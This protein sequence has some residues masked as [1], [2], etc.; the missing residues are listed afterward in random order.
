MT[1]MCRVLDAC[2]R[3]YYKW[4]LNRRS[5]RQVEDERLMQRIRTIHANSGGRYGV[6]R[7]VA[8][9][10]RELPGLG[11][12]RVQRLLRACGL[13][14][15]TWRRK[16]TTTRSGGR[17]APEVRVSRDFNRERLDE[18]WVADST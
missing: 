1:A 8:M 6:R 17:H 5:A 12:R 16:M 11:I 3:A 10:R 9:L 2:A 4:R 14:G 13:V 7:V 15:R 18:L